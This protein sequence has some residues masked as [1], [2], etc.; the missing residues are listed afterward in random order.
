MKFSAMSLLLSSFHGADSEGTKP[1][2]IISRTGVNRL[3][4]KE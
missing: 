2:Q 4:I 3:I 1:N